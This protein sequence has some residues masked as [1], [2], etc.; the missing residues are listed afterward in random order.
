MIPSKLPG[1]G[2]TIFTRMS[3]LAAF[4]WRK[5]GIAATPVAG[6]WEQP[7]PRQLLRFCLARNDAVPES[8][9]EGLCGI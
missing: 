5:R 1:V 9:A 7:P 4:C 3:T 2:T 8:A 6:S